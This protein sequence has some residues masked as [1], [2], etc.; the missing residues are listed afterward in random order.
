MIYVAQNIVLLG[1]YDAHLA[2]QDA[3]LR[4]FMEDESLLLDP[5]MD[6]TQISGL[7]SEVRERLSVVR[8]TTIVRFDATL[9]LRKVY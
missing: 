8:P 2:R 6:Y 7:S 9:I 5:Q 3:D 4:T 1:Q